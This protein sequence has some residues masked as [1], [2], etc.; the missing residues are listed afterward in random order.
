[1]DDWFLHG[2]FGLTLMDLNQMYGKKKKN[3]F[4]KIFKNHVKGR[5]ISPRRVNFLLYSGRKS[6]L[7]G[8]N[9][10][11]CRG[12]KKQEKGGVFS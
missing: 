8:G 2:D 12:E 3:Y 4:H 1:M 10:L 9:Y 11:F 7:N 5:K 6:S